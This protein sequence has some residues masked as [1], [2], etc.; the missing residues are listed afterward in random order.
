MSMG[1]IE[2][3]SHL[4]SRVK[5]IERVAGLRGRCQ[6]CGGRGKFHLAYEGEPVP[7]SAGCPACG[8]IDQLVIRH[9]HQ[10]I[11]RF[12][13]DADLHYGIAPPDRR[14]GA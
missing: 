14:D 9:V 3:P 2:M 8:K 10:T 1:R 13:D 4:Q 6:E 5:R 11:R 12:S 7:E